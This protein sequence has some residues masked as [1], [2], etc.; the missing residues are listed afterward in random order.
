MLTMRVGKL[1]RDENQS[2]LLRKLNAL[3][4]KIRHNDEQRIVFLVYVLIKNEWHLRR[5]LDKNVS[6]LER[7][8]TMRKILMS[9]YGRTCRQGRMSIDGQFQEVSLHSDDGYLHQGLF[10][11]LVFELE[12]RSRLSLDVTKLIVSFVVLMIVLLQEKNATVIF[13][14]QRS[15]FYL[16]FPL[17]LTATGYRSLTTSQKAPR[18]NDKSNSFLIHRTKQGERKSENFSCFCIRLLT[19][20]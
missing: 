2:R 19:V 14:T 8:G 15:P 11:V 7:K 1:C 4:V 5:S 20:H 17:S 16:S 9:K 6:S 10:L 12:H 18:S 13:S 3:K